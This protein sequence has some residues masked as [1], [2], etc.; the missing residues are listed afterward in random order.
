ML[1]NHIG[2]LERPNPEQRHPAMHIRAAI[3]AT[4]LI[5][6]VSAAISA[7]LS[8]QSRPYSSEEIIVATGKISQNGKAGNLWSIN[9]HP[10][11]KYRDQ[12]VVQ[13]TWMTPVGKPDFIYSPYV[14]RTVEIAGAV[15]SVLHGNAALREVWRIGIP[16]APSLQDIQAQELRIALTGS[17]SSA[18]QHVV[19][20]T[21]YHFG[22][23]LFLADSPHGCEA[24]YVPLLITAAP[25]EEIAKS[26]RP[27]TGAMIFTY[28]RDSIWSWNGAAI[29]LPAAIQLPSRSIRVNNRQYR[30]QA[31]SSAEVL[32]LLENPMGTI[33]ISRPGVSHSFP[34]GVRR[35]T[36][37][38]DFHTI[39]RVRE[40]L[41]EKPATPPENSAGGTSPL[42][43]ALLSEL[44]V[45]DDG[46]VFYTSSRA[47]SGC[48]ILAIWDCPVNESQVSSNEYKLSEAE[49]NSLRELLDNSTV[50]AP[51]PFY[52]AAPIA[53]NFDIEITRASGVQ[54][55][56]ILAFMPSHVELGDHSALLYLVC[57]SKEL[58][59]LASERNSVPL[60]CGTL[61]P[62]R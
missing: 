61:P 35:E 31:A 28:E 15:K 11:V 54:R 38:S 10:P 48:S 53:D 47:E 44:S 42:N 49:M 21:A 20:R 26:D 16:E 19:A 43:R 30:F 14:G 57:K 34:E 36:L 4:F 56:P 58:A 50:R 51:Q 12:N 46:R 6:L 37:I 2:A 59:H 13:L 25:L 62:L 8:A 9:V 60:Y 52:N 41:P 27:A 24:C 1:G 5:F 3:R 18:P 17:G 33:P 22:Y 23:F 40:I 55:L 45:F 7:A 32:K 29:I 39:F